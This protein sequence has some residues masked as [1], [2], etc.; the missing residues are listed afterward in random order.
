MTQ[1]NP[2]AV[3]VAAVRAR[4]RLRQPAVRVRQAADAR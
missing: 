3:D 4:H 2:P 1:P